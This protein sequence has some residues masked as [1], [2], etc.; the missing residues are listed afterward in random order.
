M[1]FLGTNSPVILFTFF[2]FTTVALSRY[3]LSSM[4]ADDTWILSAF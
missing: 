2:D 3:Y 4:R 1:S